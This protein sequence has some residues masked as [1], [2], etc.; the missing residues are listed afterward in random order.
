MLG[1]N[2]A[3][4]KGREDKGK[5]RGDGGRDLAQCPPKKNWRRAPYEW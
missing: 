2:M 3:D 1:S 4:A 5:G